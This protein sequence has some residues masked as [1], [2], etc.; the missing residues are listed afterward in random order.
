[1][2]QKLKKTDVFACNWG[3]LYIESCIMLWL[4]APFQTFNSF[5]YTDKFGVICEDVMTKKH[6]NLMIFQWFQQSDSPYLFYVTC[7]WN[8]KLVN[9]CW[10]SRSRWRS[11]R[12]LLTVAC[13]CSILVIIIIIIIIIIPSFPDRPL[14][15]KISETT[16]LSVTKLH[17]HVD[18]HLLSCTW[19]FSS[20]SGL[21]FWI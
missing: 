2:T 8:Y 7:L 21:P 10:P 20:R 19:Y 18:P 5:S 14:L 16:T 1:M 12:N 11:N 15:A 4:K 17:T 3:F 13:N 6:A 9:V